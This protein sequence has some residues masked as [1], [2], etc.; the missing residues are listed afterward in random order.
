MENKN[1][2]L[3]VGTKTWR[4]ENLGLFDYKSENTQNSTSII[5]QSTYF[6]RQKSSVSNKN[7]EHILF[8]IENF[9][10]DH[11]LLSSPLETNLLPTKENIENLNDKL[12][13]VINQENFLNKSEN[14]QINTNKNSD[15]YL[16]ENDIIKIG[17]EKFNINEIHISSNENNNFFYE[18]QL[19]NDYNISYMNK[20]TPPVFNFIFQENSNNFI[21]NEENSCKTCYSHENNPEN[22]LIDLCKC[23]GDLNYSHLNCIKKFL[24][25]KLNIKQ[26]QKQTVTSYYINS[27]NCEICKTPYPLKFKLNDKIYNLI[28]IEKPK[29]DYMILESL[30]QIKE[31]N[32]FKSIHVISLKNDEPIFIGR[33][34]NADIKVSDPTVSRM[35]SMLKYEINNRRI[36]IKDL[37]SSFGTLVLIKKKLEIINKIITLQIGRTFIQACI[38][39]RGKFEKFKLSEESKNHQKE[40][41]KEVE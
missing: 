26:N 21:E 37:N 15:Y 11:Y 25:L 7:T 24:K 20:N 14:N 41:V 40:E 12:Y 38:I 5:S 10:P 30:N 28:D 34:S 19:E 17:K 3:Y 2:L 29:N 32:N 13:Y 22:P 27:F 1:N 18:N 23:K 36:L 6:S 16:N 9:L 31:N 35:H 4:K 8:N 39:D 33:G